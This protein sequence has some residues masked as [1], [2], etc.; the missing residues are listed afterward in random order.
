L[1]NRR[2]SIVK[3]E[4]GK[5]TEGA[6]TQFPPPSRTMGTGSAHRDAGQLI[7]RRKTAINGALEI[8]RA[9]FETTREWKR[10]E[11]QGITRDSGICG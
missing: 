9:T 11:L 6:A 8:V 3:L 1:A 7:R 10:R 4:T 2:I 5:L